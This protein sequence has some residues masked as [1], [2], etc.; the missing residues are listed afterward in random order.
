[1][2]STSVEDAQDKLHNMVVGTSKPYCE[3]SMHQIMHPPWGRKT[4]TQPMRP[5]YAM[6][7]DICPGVVNDIV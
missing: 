5:I 2:V 1:M 7:Q 6:R 3:V 4:C